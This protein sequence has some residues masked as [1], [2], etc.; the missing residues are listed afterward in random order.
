MGAHRLA[1]RFS[2]EVSATL[3]RHYRYAEERLMRTMAGWIALT[4][5]LPAKLVF[6][7]HVWDCAQHADLWGRRLPELRA[8]AHGSEPANDGV[9]RFMDLLESREAYHATAERLTG[10]YRVLKP[11]LAA[12]YARHLADANPVYEPPTRRILERC[13][14][15]ERAHVAAG[16]TVL[17]RLLEDPGCRARALEWEATL[18]GAL[19]AARGVTGTGDGL[20]A[21]VEPLGAEVDATGVAGDLVGRGAAVDSRDVAGDLGP[22][23]DAH[24]RAVAAGDWTLAASHIVE[25]VRARVLAEYARLDP[26]FDGSGIVAHAKVGQFRVVKLRFSQ[27]HRLAVVQLQWRRFDDGW[28]VVAAELVR[29]EPPA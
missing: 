4:P 29:A 6:G 24:R 23:L 9:V 11:H 3:I 15:D 21:E 2:V 22:V 1:G 7:R 13:L 5:E 19:R 18:R 20:G 8:P 27:G 12:T 28:R 25:P 10:V 26:P 17:G 16:L 14:A